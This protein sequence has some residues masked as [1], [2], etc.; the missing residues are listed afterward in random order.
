M[1]RLTG[2]AKRQAILDPLPRLPRWPRRQAE[3]V[4]KWIEAYVRVPAGYGVGEPLRLH[5]FQRRIIRAAFG[6]PQV[7]S[8]VASLPRGN[9]KSTLAA[10]IALHFLIHPRKDP[11]QVLIV[12]ST[13][14]TAGIILD[15]CRRMVELSPDLADRVVA[16]KDRLTCPGNG[17]VLRT[18]PSN[19]AALHGHA[20][21]VLILDELHLVDEKVWSACVTSAGKRPNSRVLAISTPAATR[22]AFMWRLVQHGRIGLDP[23]FAYLEW[24]AD[25]DCDLDDERQWRKAN[26]AIAAGLLDIDGIRSVRHTTPPGRFRQLRLGQWADHDGSWIGYDE[27][28]RLADVDRTVQ[29]GERIVL[30]FDGSQRNDA[31]VLIGAT[32]PEA[33]TDPIHLFV[34]AAWVRDK[35][36]PNWQVP[37]D[38]VDIVVRQTM[39]TYAVEALAADPYFW[40]SELQRWHAEYGNVVEWSTNVS[41]QM[42]RATD[43]F[44]AAVKAPTLTHDGHELLATHIANATTRPTPA[45]DILVKHHKTSERKIDAAVA[46]CIA[47]DVAVTLGNTPKPLPLMSGVIAL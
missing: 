13:Q 10:A 43:K 39:A 15:T 31:T 5:P 19:E 18:L 9:G 47:H 16:Y 29:A 28:M 33:A 37:R 11:P 1:E 42:A 38:E 14:D 6:D 26:P 45:G 17:G 40:Q 36:D 34:V 22:E 23:T 12:A 46:A 27:W 20:P 7:R 2:G 32:I 4:I 44:F 8:M 30:G 35:L 21:T 24:A 41:K 25:E 3:Q